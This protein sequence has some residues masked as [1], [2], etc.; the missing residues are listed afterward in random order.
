MYLFAEMSDTFFYI[1]VYGILI[2]FI[3]FCIILDAFGS[4]ISF[5]FTRGEKCDK[6]GTKHTKRE[7]TVDG[8]K[9]VCLRKKCG[10]AKTISRKPKNDP[11]PTPPKAPPPPIVK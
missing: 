9:I 2:P 1:L 8:E 3:I 4:Y 6:C 11:P 7:I 10:H 5:F